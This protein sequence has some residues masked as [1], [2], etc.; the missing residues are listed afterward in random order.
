M[1]GVIE[2][3]EFNGAQ[4]YSEHTELESYKVETNKLYLR[5]WDEKTNADCWRLS[6]CT[7]TTIDTNFKLSWRN[8]SMELKS[9]YIL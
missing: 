8:K 3:V 7:G 4:L 6:H 5:N 1:Q 2:K 9:L